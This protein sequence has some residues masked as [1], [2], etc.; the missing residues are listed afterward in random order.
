M[1]ITL[2]QI[3]EVIN[4]TGATYHQA[5]EALQFSDGDVVEAII[6]LETMKKDQG[7]PD[8]PYF[9]GEE[10]IGLLK[11]M[12]KKGNVTRI[13]LEK[14]NKVVVDIPI[15]AGAL[16]ALIF[17]SASVAS[18]LAALV[19]G[20]DL[21]IIKDDGEVIDVK[22]Y[23]ET[24]VDAVKEKFSKDHKFAETEDDMAEEDEDYFHMEEVTYHEEDVLILEEEAKRDTE[25][26][27]AFAKEEP[28]DKLEIE[29]LEED[30]KEK[31]EE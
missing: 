25:P 14:N 12:I 7:A 28:T 26:V 19:A 10:I 8:R 11:D 3:D 17:T 5:K 31:T 21:K 15:L 16:G 13:T 2:E 27:E 20:C 1:N 24:K 4:R 23:T 9:N 22:E 18:I 6:Y 30:E 29:G